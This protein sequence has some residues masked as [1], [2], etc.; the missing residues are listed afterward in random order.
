MDN[1]GA[2]I[3]LP[4]FE[5]GAFRPL[6]RI[7]RADYEWRLRPMT[8]PDRRAARRR[9]YRRQPRRDRTPAHWRGGEALA[10]AAEAS[11]LAGLT[12]YGAGLSNQIVQL[13]AEDSMVALSR[14]VADLEAARQLSLDIAL[15]R[16]LGGGSAVRAPNPHTGDEMM[17]DRTAWQPKAPLPKRQKRKANGAKRKKLLRILGIVVVT[18]A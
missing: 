4:I 9:R 14:A 15:I 17:A 11:K 3:S 2:A 1:G 18:V 13:T 6:S 10:A 7:T 5:G 8:T 16:A 12:G